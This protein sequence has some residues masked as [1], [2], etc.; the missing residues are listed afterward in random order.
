MLNQFGLHATHWPD[1]EGP[2][3]HLPHGEMLRLLRNTGFEVEALHEL[4]APEGPADE[5]RHTSKA[6]LVAPLAG[7]GGQG[8]ATAGMIVPVAF[9]ERTGTRT[10]AGRSGS[11][12]TSLWRRGRR[13][14]SPGT[15]RG[16]RRAGSWSLAW[17][18]PGGT[19][20]T[21]SAETAA[22]EACRSAPRPGER[23]R[24]E[25]IAIETTDNRQV[26]WVPRELAA[27]LAPAIDAGR[28]WTVGWCFARA[29]PRPVTLAPD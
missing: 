9:E 5:V 29:D 26:G 4:Q 24:P 16:S 11:P 25:S 7:R 2:E 14:F 28:A 15:R 6:R 19:T 23:A 27:E 3:F 17:R 22:G 10:T 21:R 1:Q 18:A 8:G 12:G 20:P 13:A